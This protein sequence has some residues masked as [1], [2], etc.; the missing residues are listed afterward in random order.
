MHL[1]NLDGYVVDSGVNRSLSVVDVHVRHNPDGSVTLTTDQLWMTTEGKFANKPL[2][3]F[4]KVAN[5]LNWDKCASTKSFFV[6][7]KEVHP[8]PPSQWPKVI[9]ETVQLLPGRTGSQV[10]AR[11]TFDF[12]SNSKYVGS[13]YRLAAR[14]AIT[15]DR[16]YV[17]AVPVT[18]QWRDPDT[19][20]LENVTF[21]RLSSEKTIEFATGGLGPD[22]FVAM[23]WG[24]GAHRMVECAGPATAEAGDR[25]DLGTPIE[26][27]RTLVEACLDDFDVDTYSEAYRRIALSGTTGALEA[28]GKQQ[29]GGASSTEDP[30]NMFRFAADAWFC[31][32]VEMWDGVQ[33][34]TNQYLQNLSN[35]AGR[36][37]TTTPPP[38]TV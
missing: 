20:V 11:L 34:L 6:K 24:W 33:D 13:T 29:K 12:A 25:Y 31:S 5:P 2:S 21:F 32:A 22:P 10:T 3:A 23:V 17:Q 27:L 30:V 35:Y 18:I 28:L 36:Y 7:M 15:E 4:D 37:P 8:T 14:G 38:S 16:G 26:M 1:P 19:G 9:D